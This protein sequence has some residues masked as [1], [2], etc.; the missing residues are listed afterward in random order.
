V[1]EQSLALSQREGHTEWYILDPRQQPTIHQRAH[2]PSCLA[3][4]YA[5]QGR[6]MA[7]WHRAEQHGLFEQRFHLGIESVA[8]RL[9]SN[10]LPDL[11]I[12]AEN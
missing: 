2:Q 5:N 8:S 7:P 12:S 3:F 9:N 10:E 4:A 11:L 6:H 1:R